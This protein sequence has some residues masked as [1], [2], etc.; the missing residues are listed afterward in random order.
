MVKTD[1]IRLTVLTPE[2]TLFEG[3][4]SKVELPGE[5]GRFVVLQNHA[6]IISSLVAG[7][8][9]YVSENHNDSVAVKAGFARVNNNEVVV[10]A[11]V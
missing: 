4:V 10:C 7:S 2:K 3:F 8:V 5:K 1:N 6:P 11:E 9:A